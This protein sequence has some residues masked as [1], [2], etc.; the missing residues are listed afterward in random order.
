MVGQRRRKVC[1]FWQDRGLQGDKCGRGTGWVGRLAL[2]WRRMIAVHGPQRATNNYNVII[3]QEGCECERETVRRIYA[4]H[5]SFGKLH[6][7]T[8]ENF[9]FFSLLYQSQS[10]PS[11]FSLINHLQ[12]F[13]QDRLS[14]FLAAGLTASDKIDLLQ[15]IP[16]SY[17]HTHVIFIRLESSSLCISLSKGAFFPTLH[18]SVFHTFSPSFASTV[19]K[20]FTNFRALRREYRDIVLPDLCLVLIIF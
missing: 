8:S 6:Q 20:F 9:L 16:N 19:S 17:T 1:S 5:Y 14:C 3:V 7:S 11:S 10:K 4:P 2:W 15:S 18:V 13:I 12:S